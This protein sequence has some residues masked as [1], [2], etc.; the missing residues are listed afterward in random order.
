M[1]L[2]RMSCSPRERNRYSVRT[3]ESVKLARTRACPSLDPVIAPA[4]KR[5]DSGALPNKRDEGLLQGRAV[6]TAHEGRDT[7]N[8]PTSSLSPRARKAHGAQKLRSRFKH[9]PASSPPWQCKKQSGRGG[10]SNARKCTDVRRPRMTS[11]VPSSR[12]GST[13]CP[14]LR[15]FLLLVLR[16]VVARQVQA[17]VVEAPPCPWFS[18]PSPLPL[19]VAPSC[20]GWSSR[21]ACSVEHHVFQ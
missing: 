7:P 11:S 16:S 15:S 12:S 14:S 8:L 3:R 13:A 17:M 4:A 19:G 6:P 5:L 20:I 21:P 18:F 2:A 9:E 10:V 1:D